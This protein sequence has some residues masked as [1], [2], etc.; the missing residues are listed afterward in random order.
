MYAETNATTMVF[1]SVSQRPN[2]PAYRKLCR[3]DRL[4]GSFCKTGL[5][6]TRAD[7]SNGV[8]HFCSFAVPEA[9]T[10]SLPLRWLALI[11]F[12]FAALTSHRAAFEDAPLSRYTIPMARASNP[13]LSSLPMR[14]P[15]FI[16][17][18]ECLAVSRLPEGTEWIYTL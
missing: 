5:I 1:P 11:P 15:A 18:M 10:P 14:D 12:D 9:L 7:Q 6:G 2:R 8:L 16:K 13:R 3:C 4:R 17:P